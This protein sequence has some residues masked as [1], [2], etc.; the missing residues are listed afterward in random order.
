MD[1]REESLQ[2]LELTTLQLCKSQSTLYRINQRCVVCFNDTFV[3]AFDGYTICRCRLVVVLERVRM[4]LMI[5]V[6]CR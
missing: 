6:C 4:H 2:R 3:H 1:W 5:C